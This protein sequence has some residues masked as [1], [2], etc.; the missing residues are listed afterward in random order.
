MHS[1]PNTG[2]KC[3]FFQVYGNVGEAPHL[4]ENLARDVCTMLASRGDRDTLQSFNHGVIGG[5]NP[6]FS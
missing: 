1:I 6:E 3:R 4:P 2:I 5:E